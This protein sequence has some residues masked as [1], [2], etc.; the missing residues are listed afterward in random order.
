MPYTYVY[1]D[2]HEHPLI[3][4]VKAGE[5][6]V[7]DIIEALKEAGGPLTQPIEGNDTDMAVTFVFEGNFDGVGI[8]TQLSGG[9]QMVQPMER[10]PGTDLWLYQSVAPIDIRA[11]YFFVTNPPEMTVALDDIDSF[12]AQ[13][14]ASWSKGL[15]DPYN[16]VSDTMDVGDIVLTVSMIEG[17]KAPPLLYREA[18]DGKPCGEWHEHMISSSHLDAP[19]KVWVH[20]PVHYDPKVKHALLV[21]HDGQAWSSDG[22]FDNF[23]D[24]MVEDGVIQPTIAVCVDS[25]GLV[26]RTADLGLSD[27]YADFIAEDVVSW[28]RAHYPVENSADATAMTGASMGGLASAF[29]SLRHPNVIG[30]SLPMSPSLFYFRDEQPEWTLSFAKGQNQFPS[31]MYIGVGSLEKDLVPPAERLFEFLEGTSCD[32]DLEIWSGAHD[33]PTWYGG[34]AN[35]LPSIFPPKG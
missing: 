2:E 7:Q 8:Q 3:S 11:S 14:L 23:L 35:G 31:R 17:P 26:A 19:R 25:G 21:V 12:T 22:L 1:T 30:C 5:K 6:D 13:V 9:N 15:P 32:V 27:A 33:V 4:A 20:T 34:M 18:R 16:P 29:I 10:L 28:M 24:N